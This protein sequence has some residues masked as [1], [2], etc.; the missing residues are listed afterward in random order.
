MDAAY[1]LVGIRFP[2]AVIHLKAPW[3]DPRGGVGPYR[4]SPG[5]TLDG[6]PVPLAHAQGRGV[7]SF[8]SAM[9]SGRRERVQGTSCIRLCSA[10]GSRAPTD[11][12]M[13][14]SSGSARSQGGV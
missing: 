1:Q 13:G 7:P 8:R 11:S 9:G 12:T 4:K 14:Y 5:G 2:V 6:D 10:K 3:Q